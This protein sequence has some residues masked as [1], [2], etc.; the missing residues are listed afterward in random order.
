[1]LIVI[2][3]EPF[4][5]VDILQT[6]E[7]TIVSLYICLVDVTASHRGDGGWGCLLILLLVSLFILFGDVLYG[8][9]DSALDLC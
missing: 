7:D 5:P 8:T 2:V 1:M 9:C 3:K 6:L 4:T